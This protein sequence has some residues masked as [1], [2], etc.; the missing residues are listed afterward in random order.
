MESVLRTE[1]ETLAPA[2][3]V[4]PRP[5]LRS[6]GFDGLFLVVFPLVAVA[7]G[8]AASVDHRLFVPL[9]TLD[10]WL[11]G[12]HHVGATFTKLL[13]DPDT[14]RNNVGLWTWLPIAVVAATTLV[15][16]GTA[17]WLIATVYLHW[18]WYHYTRQSWGIAESFRRRDPAATQPVDRL[19]RA[20]FWAVPI[21]GMLWRSAEG[22]KD[23][24]GMPVRLVPVPRP[25]AVL[26]VAAA[27]LIVGVWLLRRPTYAQGG[28]PYMATHIAIFT[29]AYILIPWLSAGWLAINV[30]HNCQYIAFVWHTNTR[31]HRDDHTP[32][33]LLIGW[34][35]APRRWPLYLL[36]TL[37]VTSSVYAAVSRATGWASAGAATV[38]MGI[39]FHHY[40]VDSRVWKLAK[41][42]LRTRLG[43]TAAAP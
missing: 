20:A 37:A 13:G 6:P 9:L 8:V 15:A 30:W 26:A 40:V 1:I 14:R 24:L 43:L 11:L 35:S 27:A 23:F 18:Q 3:N 21:A 2:A 31:L 34:L 29:I 17:P 28:T 7:C 32:K 25:V 12:Y 4:A 22:W 42:S 41:P 19:G 5:L 38:F 39:N 33:P 36:A 16:A 10:L